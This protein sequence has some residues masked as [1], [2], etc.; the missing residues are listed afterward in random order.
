MYC[1]H[2]GLNEL[3]FNMTPNPRLVYQNAVVEEVLSKLRYCIEAK[4]GFFLLTGEAGT[5]KTTLLRLLMRSFPD[6]VAYAYIFNPRLKFSALLHG[7]LND[8][9]I[10]APVADKES[11]LERLNSYALEQHKRGH[12]VACILDE[13]QGLSDEA[14]EELRLL[15]NLETDSEKLIQIILVGQPELERR[16]DQAKL[17]QLKQ[18]ISH[19]H[20]LNPL[21]AHEVGPYIGARLNQAGYKGDPLFSPTAVERISC[22]SRG[23]PRVINSICDNALGRAWRV[24]A[25]EITAELIDEAAVELRLFEPSPEAMPA[26]LVNADDQGEGE[27]AGAGSM[28]EC[29]ERPDNEVSSDGCGAAA[30]SCEFD[31]P[32]GPAVLSRRIRL[33]RIAIGSLMTVMIS[34]LGGVALLTPRGDGAPA[35]MKLS[36][37]DVRSTMPAAAAPLNSPTISPDRFGAQAPSA[38]PSTSDQPSVTPTVANGKEIAEPSREAQPAAVQARKIVRLP[39]QA[40]FRVGATS[41]LRNKPTA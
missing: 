21:Q 6:S 26:G 15:G 4:E 38:T 41:F 25:H 8:L 32:S 2:F 30:L 3:P 1:K 36:R 27:V 22:Y 7:L 37:N 10:P 13:A 29:A 33:E 11:M 5:G 34:V 16:L 9:G 31:M 40:I 23:I 35:P 28:S 20:V 18:R 24:G 12:I 39:S 19:R 14:L 17:R